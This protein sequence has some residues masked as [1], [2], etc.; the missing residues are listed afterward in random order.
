VADIERWR[1]TLS[2]TEAGGRR[3]IAN[4]MIVFI[5]DLALS[6]GTLR[7]A[8]PASTI[9]AFSA[10]LSELALAASFRSDGKYRPIDSMDLVL[11]GDTLDLI[12]SATWLATTARPW[13]NPYDPSVL[14]TVRQITFAALERNEFCLHGLRRLAA[15]DAICLPRRQ[16]KPRECGEDLQCVPVRIHYVV[17]DRDWPLHLPGGEYD[18]LRSEI[19]SRMGLAN[20]ASLPFP[21]DTSENAEPLRAARRHRVAARHGDIYDPIHFD[22]DRNRSGLADLV[23]IELLA[24]FQLDIE[25]LHDCVSASCIAGLRALNGVRPILFAAAWIDAVLQKTCDS[26]SR[27]SEIDATWNRLV[28]AL[29]DLPAIRNCQGWTPID[30]ADVLSES[31][32]IGLDHRFGRRAIRDFRL[33]TADC[34]QE[35]QRLNAIA[36][37]GR[38]SGLP[39]HIVY[40]HSGRTDAVAFQSTAGGKSSP[41]FFNVGTWR[42]TISRSGVSTGGM[43]P[44]VVVYEPAERCGQTFDLVAGSS[45]RLGRP[46]AAA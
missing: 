45:N 12:G 37:S 33:A 44:M 21:Q 29:I 24:R 27:R 18:R 41:Y 15:G 1:A 7:P 38:G 8:M 31:L 9:E 17:G 16:P 26:D 23:A 11:L 39:V 3:F 32:L 4:S 2:G 13:Q 14:S 20:P 22:S 19:V 6:D 10:K 5:S 25:Q 40:G 34:A 43:V 30:L 35:P 28:E 46:S 42:P 36:E